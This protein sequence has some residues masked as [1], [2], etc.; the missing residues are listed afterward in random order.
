MILKIFSLQGY[1]RR[2]WLLLLSLCFVLQFF[3]VPAVDGGGGQSAAEVLRLKTGAREAALG[4]AGQATARG[5][6]AIDY[7]PAGLLPG[8]G[9]EFE[10]GYTSL[11][12]DIDFGSFTY[13]HSPD[14]VGNQSAL[15]WGVNYISYG[16]EQRTDVRD[17]KLYTDG[18][19]TG[20]DLVG[21]AGYGRQI[22]ENTSLGFALR[23]IRLEIDD[24]TA[25]AASLDLGLRWASNQPDLPLAFGFVIA[26]LG[27]EVEFEDEGDDLPLLARGGLSY[28][29][30]E[31]AA[32]PVELYLD[33]E[34]QIENS[35]ASLMLGTEIQLYNDLDF[36]L[37]YNSNREIDDGMS[38]GLGLNFVDNLEFDYAFVPYGDFGDLHQLGFRYSF[39][40]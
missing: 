29:L 35:R 24:S 39:G 6:K 17:G 27:T 20:L 19:F 18:D 32:F 30:R 15:G 33:T 13:T 16:D 7:N 11:V 4:S 34:Y 25:Q 3:A 9:S 8:E 22:N 28:A 5:A 26:N 38:V 31:N 12:E 21:S 14:F 40:E 10:L 37:G 1:L 23:G 2:P 36:R